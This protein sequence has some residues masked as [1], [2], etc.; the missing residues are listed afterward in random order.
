MDPHEPLP[1][2]HWPTTREGC[3]ANRSGCPLVTAFTHSTSAAWWP[4]RCLAGSARDTGGTLPDN[5]RRHDMTVPNLNWI[6]NYVC[7]IVDDV[8]RDVY[9]CGEY[10]DLILPMTVLRRLDAV[11]QA[12]Q[13]H[14]T[15]LKPRWI[16]PGAQTRTPRS[17]RLGRPSTA[18]RRK[19]NW[20]CVSVLPQPGRSGSFARTLEPEHLHISTRPSLIELKTS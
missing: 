4:L 10:R 8:L 6:A 12:H 5:T 14:R 15:R 9:V 16:P 20:G 19:A 11:A 18:L 17:R 13:A 7:G 1:S 2:Q 3:Q